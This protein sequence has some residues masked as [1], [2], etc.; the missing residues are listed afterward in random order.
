MAV[1]TLLLAGMA[2]A[3]E[4]T[5]LPNQDRKPVVQ[6]WV[7]VENMS[8]EFDGVEDVTI[9]N[10]TFENIGYGDDTRYPLYASPLL[11]PAQR[12]GDRKYHR[13]IRFTNNRIKSFNGHFVHAMS[14]QGQTITGNTIELGKDY[15][16]G[17]TRP[18]IEL[19]YCEDVTIE[20]NR[21]L[22]FDWPIRIEQS[23]ATA[24]V[25]LKNNQGLTS[26]ISTTRRSP[27]RAVPAATT[28]LAATIALSPYHMPNLPT[29]R[30][31]R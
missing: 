4:P 16:T 1:L 17:S 24:D 26:I 2:P 29:V 14:V 13:N 22:G 28:R 12:L 25:R 6:K 23:A 21:F 8:D 10:N 5:F 11:R 18:S 3:S 9:T 19:E 15:P 27:H 20:D 31:R 30:G 7:L